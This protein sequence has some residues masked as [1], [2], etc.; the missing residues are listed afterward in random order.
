[1]SLFILFCFARALLCDNRFIRVFRLDEAENFWNISEEAE[2]PRI[3][4]A[5][6]LAAH[7]E[8]RDVKHEVEEMEDAM[9]AQK[10]GPPAQLSFFRLKRK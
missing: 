2:N 5:T 1:M 9:S 6:A 3:R 8:D 10:P 7:G 4:N